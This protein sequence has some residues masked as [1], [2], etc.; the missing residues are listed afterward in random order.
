MKSI[1]L[2]LCIDLFTDFVDGKAIFSKYT[3][4]N[5]KLPVIDSRRYPK[6]KWQVWVEIEKHNFICIADIIPPFS[7]TNRK[8]LEDEIFC[9][10]Q[11]LTKDINGDQNEPICCH[12]I[13]LCG[14]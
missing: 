7:E 11:I 3:T 10:F 5:V 8:I 9:D 12:K 6:Q 14:N 2:A 1:I 13:F 4:G